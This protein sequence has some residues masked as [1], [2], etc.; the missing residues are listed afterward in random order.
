ME[1][2]FKKLINIESNKDKLKNKLIFKKYRIIN[3]IGKGSFGFVYSGENIHNHRKVAI[4][5]EKKGAAYHLLEKEG[6]FLSL[7]K[8]PGIP[9]IISY[10]KNINY[11][12]LV[13]ELLGQNLWQILKSMKFKKFNTNDLS[14]IA[15]Q[16]L[17]RIEYIHSK[18]IVHRDIKP[19]NFL[20]GLENK[21]F[22]YLID[23]GISRKYRSDKTG[24]HIRYTL[25][26]KLFGTLKFISYNA[27]R[28]VE[29]SRRDDMIS[30]GYMLAFL[31]GNRLPWQGYEI[32]GPNA[33]SNYEKIVEL[34]HISKPEQICRGLPIEFCN[35]LKYCK[36][37]NFEQE[38]NYEYLRTLFKQVLQRNQ[39]D[40]YSE[41][42]FNRQVNIIK[43]IN[44]KS[45]DKN[46]NLSTMSN[47]KYINLLRR[48]QSPQT[49]LFHKIEKNLKL[50]SSDQ[51]INKKAQNEIKS[52]TNH[53][54][55]T[56]SFISTH[57]SNSRDGH[58]NDSF[59]VQY[60]FDITAIKDEIKDNN[61]KTSSIENNNINI[62]TSINN[63]IN[64]NDI[65]QNIIYDYNRT[66]ERKKISTIKKNNIKIN[67]K[68]FNTSIDLDKKFIFYGI[69]LGIKKKYKSQS[70]KNQTKNKK[71]KIKNKELTKENK[72][73]NLCKK[74]Y[75][76]ILKKFCF[77]GSFSSSKTTQNKITTNNQIKIFSFKKNNENLNLI[78]ENINLNNINN[79]R[80]F[81]VKKN[82]FQQLTNDN[83]RNYGINSN[84]IINNKNIYNE[85]SPKAQKIITLENKRLIKNDLKNRMK[86]NNESRVND[87]NKNKKIIII[88]NNINSFNNSNE[89][90]QLHNI[91]DKNNNQIPNNIRKK[92]LTTRR[93]TS[94]IIQN[95]SKIL[96][97]DNFINNSTTRNNSRNVINGIISTNANKQLL[98][99]I[100]KF[101]NSYNK[102]IFNSTNTNDS[103]N[104]SIISLP[105]NLKINKSN[106]DIRNIQAI[107]KIKIYNYKS[108]YAPK[109][110]PNNS[111]NNIITP[112][113]VVKNKYIEY[114]LDLKRQMNVM[115]LNN[116][117]IS[118]QQQIKKSIIQLVNPENNYLFN[119]NLF[120]VPHFVSLENTFNPNILN[121]KQ[122]YGNISSDKNFY[123]KINENNQ[124]KLIVSKSNLNILERKI[125]A[126]KRRIVK[127]NNGNNLDDFRSYE[128]NRKT[129]FNNN[130]NNLYEPKFGYALNQYN[131]LYNYN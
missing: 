125:K 11:Y 99:Y 72:R 105:N 38:P 86:I 3:K 80:L 54:K 98:N 88:N 32:H 58:S 15:I 87:L 126:R 103:N 107:K 73:R 22:I 111:N 110:S 121:N 26:G 45:R 43:Y 94:P 35:Y 95:N 76:N 65:V 27:A 104:R 119:R 120:P 13:E 82:N 24:K 122:N 128:K 96:R 92:Y 63:K 12:I 34:K 44:S 52:Y 1:K 46:A 116:S 61:N 56:S 112:N 29:Q 131:N 129:N 68:N 40:I 21:N 47:E 102:S 36:D 23:F 123:N 81:P 75:E 28:G 89:Q 41:F 127:Y 50:I 42:S 79:I 74:I 113:R 57:S 90:N 20:L 62:N 101:N 124:N 70:P 78:N 17:D 84:N 83:N 91:I 108:I 30:I 115:K 18:N 66:N 117:P 49:R 14:K 59:Q 6:M 33:K 69:N 53:Q 130:F 55:G 9:E 16:I 4:K 19:E 67:K 51:T 25:T 48:K 5:F 106:D 100:P 2:F 39:I 114:P 7:L 118:V 109:Q 10:G 37:L 93:I 85:C 31:A 71:P 64:R 77:D 8:G 60:S 97:N